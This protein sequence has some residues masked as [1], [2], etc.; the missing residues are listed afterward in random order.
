MDPNWSD[1]PEDAMRRLDW[2]RSDD[3]YTIPAS[4]FSGL[5]DDEA[6]LR[7]DLM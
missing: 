5:K 3:Q 2:D 6:S 7:D 4:A 1:V